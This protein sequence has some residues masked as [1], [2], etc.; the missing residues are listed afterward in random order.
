[1][2]FRNSNPTGKWTRRE[3]ETIRKLLY[4]CVGFSWGFVWPLEGETTRQATGLTATSHSCYVE[5]RFRWLMRS[6]PGRCIYRLLSI[7]HHTPATPLRVIELVNV[8]RSVCPQW[9]KRNGNSHRHIPCFDFKTIVLVAG[10]RCSN[11]FIVVSWERSSI[12][13]SPKK[14][15]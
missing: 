12:P 13:C 2:R 6:F 4:P 9:R 5:N 7:G 3:P 15:G 1:M 8:R 14:G 10:N 11:L